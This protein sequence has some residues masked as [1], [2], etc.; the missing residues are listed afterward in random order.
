MDAVLADFRSWLETIADCSNQFT[1][2]GAAETE[3][4]PIDLH[5]LLGQF[6]ALRQEV[7]LQTKATR[8]QQEQN[9]ESLRYLGEAVEEVRAGDALAKSDAARAL[10]EA[11]R[12]LLKT[13]VDVVDSLHLALRE[14]QRLEQAVGAT[15]GEVEPVEASTTTAPA[16]QHS[17][18]W[19][20]W[21]L[22][23]QVESAPTDVA[24]TPNAPKLQ[25]AAATA[26][27]LLESLL[28]GYTMSL[29]RA[30]RALAQH[31]LERIPCAGQPFD[32]EQMEVVEVVADS[33]EPPGVVID[34]IRPGYRWN[35]RIFRYAQ[36]RVARPK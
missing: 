27:E 28:T 22:S 9:R 26:H 4:E 6:I 8:A 15:L 23:N 21:W 24:E 35:G 7:N 2:H 10:E 19:K 16:A 29:Q 30:Q 32:P 1:V 25:E 14:A 36:V 20:R 11:V 12:P 13:L 34:E 31:G 17:S 33:T 18:W 5:T 3:A